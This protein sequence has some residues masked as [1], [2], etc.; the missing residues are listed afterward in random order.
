M[1]SVVGEPLMNWR[2]VP[3]LVKERLRRSWWSA[4]GSRPFSSRNDCEGGAEPGDVEG[5]LDRATVAA[6]ADEGAV[7]A[8][9][10]GEVESANENGFAGAGFAGN[11]VVAGLQFERQVGHEGEVLD[12]QGCQHVAVPALNLAVMRA[13]GKRKV[14]RQGAHVG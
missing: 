8:L 1:A 13:M 11:D 12:A 9:A 4:Q 10:Q 2:L 14:G 5:G 3:A 7:G 6:A